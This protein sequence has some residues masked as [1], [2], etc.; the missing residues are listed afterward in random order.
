[1]GFSK[2]AV[3]KG[4]RSLDTVYRAL[5]LV[6]YREALSGWDR[7]LIKVN[8]ITT[9]NWETGA[10][11]DPMVVEAIINRVRELGKEPLVV[12]SDAQMTN[13]DKAVVVSGMK[14]MLDR[15]GVPFVNM[16]H[17][18]EKVE[19]PVKGGKVL[20]SIKVAKIATESAIISAA[21]LKTHMGTGVTLGMKN[22]FGMLT[23]K[24]K[25][26]YH[27]NDMHKVI[28]DI[29]VTLP[30]TLTVIDGFVAMEGRG[31]VHGTPVRM[32]TIIAGTDVV[33]TDSVACRVMGFTQDE[34]DHIAWAHRSGLG[35]MDDVDV[36][37]DG[38][39]AV[40]RVFTRF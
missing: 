39:D 25:G 20:S 16:R 18:A 30:P 2:V 13:A 12:E 9:K 33:A 38:V 11:T 23:T 17:V 14:E 31:P 29:C 34:V 40:R 24:W 32:G 15:V 36:V 5:D 8:F 21:K 4:E 22:M 6:P 26:R 10:T 1:M 28:H 37:G 19:L 27:I 7:V 35:A 3:V